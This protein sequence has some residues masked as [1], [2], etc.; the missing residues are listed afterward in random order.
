MEHRIKDSVDYR[1]HREYIASAG[2][3]APYFCR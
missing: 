1:N 3:K 2:A